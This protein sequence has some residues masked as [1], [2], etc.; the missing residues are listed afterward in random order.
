MSL[1]SKIAET[2]APSR[3][4]RLKRR[5]SRAR[6]GIAAVEAALVFPL[7]V[8]LLLG[9]WEVSRLV[10]VYQIVNNAVR[11]GGRQAAAGQV[12]NSAVQQ[13]VLNYMK[14]AG[15]PTTHATVTVSDLTTPGTDATNAAELD[16]IQ[17]TA[18]IPFSDVRWLAAMLVTNSSTS[19]SVT[20]VWWS[21]NNQN[22]PTNISVPQAY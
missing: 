14:N 4:A 13:V 2:M 17:I 11:E 22:Y 12:S 9:T 21:N 5:R 19:V 20:S 18:S 10:E 1:G 8:T 16:M 7:M 15:L 6:R 3:A